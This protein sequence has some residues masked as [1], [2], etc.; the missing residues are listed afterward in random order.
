MTLEFMAVSA[1][2]VVTLYKNVPP[3]LFSLIE[4]RMGS[5]GKMGGLSF[6]S[7]SCTVTVLSL[8]SRNRAGAESHTSTLN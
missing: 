2:V 6:M 1:S 5:A 4:R 8:H 7:R 3:G